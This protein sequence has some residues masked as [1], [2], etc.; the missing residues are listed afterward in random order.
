[1]RRSCLGSILHRLRCYIRSCSYRE[2][3]DWASWHYVGGIFSDVSERV[4][5][6]ARHVSFVICQI[7]QIPNRV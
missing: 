2:R 4:L 6:S 7:A 3:L 5:Y 1:M